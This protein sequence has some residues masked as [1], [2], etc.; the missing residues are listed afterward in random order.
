MEIISVVHFT[1]GDSIEL[2]CNPF[3]FFP[4]WDDPVNFSNNA[5]FLNP[6]GTR[7]SVQRE[8]S[9]EVDKPGIDYNWLIKP[10][11]VVVVSADK[12]FCCFFLEGSKVIDHRRIEV[13][14]NPRRHDISSTLRL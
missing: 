2:I 3:E 1:E 4:L 8:V 6:T 10:N 14:F 11:L 13:G 5:R 9:D 7:V 12:E